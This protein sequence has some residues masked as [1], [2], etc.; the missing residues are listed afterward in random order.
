MQKSRKIKFIIP[1]F[2]KT[3]EKQVNSGAVEK[4]LK[5]NHKSRILMKNSVFY[6]K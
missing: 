4:S 2:F 5:N 1:V 6:C 3:G